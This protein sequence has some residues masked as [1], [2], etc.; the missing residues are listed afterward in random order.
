MSF[1][2]ELS[3]FLKLINSMNK[4][5]YV[6]EILKVSEVGN[7]LVSAHV[8][9]YFVC[10][11][12]IVAILFFKIIRTV[13]KVR[14]PISNISNKV[15]SLMLSFICSVTPLIFSVLLFYYLKYFMLS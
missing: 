14:I 10:L 7:V 9:S 1:P 5:G 15:V 6:V 2:R 4:T 13:T 11:Y 12:V 3:I 8:L